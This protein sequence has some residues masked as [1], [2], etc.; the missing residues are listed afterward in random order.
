[1]KV[2]KPYKHDQ[3]YGSSNPA[4][5]DRC[6]MEVNR[7]NGSWTFWTQ[8]SGP[9]KFDRIVDGQRVKVCHTHRPE[10]VQTREAAK[11]EREEKRHRQAMREWYRP[12]EYR[13]A[14]QKIA[15]GDNDPRAVAR[16]ALQKWGDLKVP[17][18]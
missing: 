8:C 3:I 9:A 2:F 13:E 6:A 5:P 17:T 15:D 1:V 7:P 10:V 16:E 14:L 18:E 11:K 12:G 4:K